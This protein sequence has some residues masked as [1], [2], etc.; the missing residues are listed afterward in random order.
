ML[1]NT[2]I[3]TFTDIQETTISKTLLMVGVCKQ[4]IENN[5]IHGWLEQDVYFSKINDSTIKYQSV[6]DVPEKVLLIFNTK[7]VPYRVEY[8][9]RSTDDGLTNKIEIYRK[10]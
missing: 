10:D 6:T 5:N 2:I 9:S 3:S 8:I 7:N 4:E 1:I